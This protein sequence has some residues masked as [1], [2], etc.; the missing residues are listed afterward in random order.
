MTEYLSK[1]WKSQKYRVIIPV[2]HFLLSFIYE[3]TLF[4]FKLDKNVVTAISMNF[5]ISD[6]AE[7]I[8]GYICTK[9]FALILIFAFWKV[10]FGVWDN[11]KKLYV[12]A[13]IAVFLGLLAVILATYP[14]F[15]DYSVD[16]YVAYSYGIRFWPE[17]W[18]SAYTSLVFGGLLMIFPSPL[19]ICIM[20]PFFGMAGIGYLCERIGDSPVIKGKG[21]GF[22]WLLILI[23]NLFYVYACPSRINF[24]SIFTVFCFSLI[25]MDIVD[26]KSRPVADRVMILLMMAFFS[27][28]RTEGIIIG[29]LSVTVLVIFNYGKKKAEIVRLMALYLAFVV[30]IT[31]P[32]KLGDIKYYGRDYEIYNSFGVLKNII[33]DPKHDLSYVE[34][35][36]DLDAVAAVIPIDMLATQKEEGYRRYNYANGR[37]DIN[38]SM[39]GKEKTNA[40]LSAYRRLV[41]HNPG[42]YFKTQFITMARTMGFKKAEYDMPYTGEIVSDY[43]AWDFVGFENGREDILTRKLTYW[44]TINI[45]RQNMLLK[46]VENFYA[47]R[48]FKVS[49]SLTPI[50]C[51]SICAAMLLLGVIGVIKLIKKKFEGIEFSLLGIFVLGQMVAIMLVMPLAC[52]DYIQ[53]TLFCGMIVIVVRLASLVALRKEKK[54]SEENL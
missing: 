24:Y 31:V 8:F 28:W 17:Y 29:L 43:S 5:V 7:R 21:K 10:I 3:R 2:I 38:Q 6:K 11:R 35:E 37:P 54:P 9:A 4:I 25:V 40:Y 42:I 30:V 12:W 27:V 50:V 19:T 52:I 34:A 53:P 41:M 48:D 26:K 49:I 22:A 47:F 45:H 32:Q 14:F 33:N 16:S 36:D 46:F 23:P 13:L 39:A 51:I 20:M 18:H 44:W 15:P 1:T